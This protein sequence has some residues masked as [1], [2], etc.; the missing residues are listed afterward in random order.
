M[1]ERLTATDDA[2]RLMVFWDTGDKTVLPADFLR[3]KAKDALS[4]RERVNHG[5]VTVAPGITITGLQQVGNGVNIQFSDGHDKAIYPFP[6]LRE[7]SSAF[8]K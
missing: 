7:L 8:D 1:I 2:T 6:Y 4:V 5:A 3:Q